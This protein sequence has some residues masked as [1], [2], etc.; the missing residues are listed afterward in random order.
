MATS[1][2]RPRPITMPDASL[3]TYLLALLGPEPANELLEIRFR[4][5]RAGMGQCFHRADDLDCAARV[6]RGL[7][8]R[9]DVYVGAAPRSQRSGGRRAVRHVWT[10]WADCDDADSSARLDAFKPGPSIVVC[11]GSPGARHAYWVLDAPLTPDAAETANRGLALALGADLRST[12]AARILR[13]PGTLNF[14]HSPPAEVVLEH[15]CP[16]RLS[17][18][19][20]LVDTPRIPVAHVRRPPATVTTC[21]DDPLRRVAPDEYVRLL[22]G[23]DVPHNRK[24]RCPFHDDHTP[25]LLVY[26][27][28]EGGWYCYGCGRGT[29]IYDMGAAVYGRGTRGRDFREVRRRLLRVIRERG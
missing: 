22:L 21:D 11:S 2:T 5:P 25:S 28:P 24:I 23:V 3:H 16:E 29:S 19:D 9:T 18:H 7:G 14:K 26:E 20:V 13:P 27:T 1:V 8:A 12:D 4:R 15:L 6:I 17:A 10:L